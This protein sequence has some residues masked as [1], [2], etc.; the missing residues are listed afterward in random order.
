M[1]SGLFTAG[2]L[3]EEIEMETFL[4]IVVGVSLFLLFA[5]VL[6]CACRRRWNSPGPTKA[7]TALE[8]PSHTHNGV[9]NLIPPLFYTE[10]LCDPLMQEDLRDRL[11][12]VEPPTPIVRTAPSIL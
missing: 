8:I 9:P 4:Y 7:S 1:D 11:R 6:V 10:G 5:I 2:P 3:P 12:H